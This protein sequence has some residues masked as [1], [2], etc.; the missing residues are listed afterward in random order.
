MDF[1]FP[2]TLGIFGGKESNVNRAP[3][4]STCSIEMLIYLEVTNMH[5]QGIACTISFQT[6]LTSAEGKKV[7]G[8]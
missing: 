8:F 2:L 4:G 6:G 7:G 5:C 3:D 1:F